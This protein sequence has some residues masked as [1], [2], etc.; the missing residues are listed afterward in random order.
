MNIIRFRIAESGAK[1]D[2]VVSTLNLFLS[3]LSAKRKYY[4]GNCSKYEEIYV[5]VH[6]STHKTIY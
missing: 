3:G 6:E 5:I 4:I 2:D 1:G